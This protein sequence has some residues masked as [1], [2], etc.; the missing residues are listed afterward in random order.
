MKSIPTSPAQ[1]TAQVGQTSDGVL[2]NVVVD[3]LYQDVSMA[4]VSKQACTTAQQPTACACQLGMNLQVSV[5]SQDQRHCH[6][7]ETIA[8]I[9]LAI[10]CSRHCFGH[11]SLAGCL[12]HW[13]LRE[14]LFQELA[15]VSRVSN[16]LAIELQDRYLHL[17]IEVP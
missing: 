16:L 9:L 8:R 2:F 15:D 6:T 7:F 17:K 14:F 11:T 3:D 4:D 12:E 10:S 13:W 5:S 1:H